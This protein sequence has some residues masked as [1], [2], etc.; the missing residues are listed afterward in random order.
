MVVIPR[1]AVPTVKVAI[2]IDSKL[3]DRLD[4]F[5]V[6]KRFAGRSGAIQMAI[7]A[8][9]TRFE[10]RRLARECAKLE[11]RSEQRLAEKAGSDLEGWPKY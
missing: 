3:L 7:E 10:R 5:V 9:L 11:L 4:R 1:R 2:S 8:A 6:Q